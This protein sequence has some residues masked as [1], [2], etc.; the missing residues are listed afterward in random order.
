MIW[1]S[2]GLVFLTF[3]N[4]S[5]YKIWNI[6]AAN[7]F[8]VV[9]FGFSWNLAIGISNSVSI[10]FYSYI[11]LRTAHILSL[12]WCIHMQL[13][14][15]C[16]CFLHFCNLQFWKL[17]SLAN[18]KKFNKAKTYLFVYFGVLHRYWLIWLP[19]G[20]DIFEIRQSC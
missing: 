11:Y 8:L 6:H 16:H 12:G 18:Q 14:N 5:S 3:G 13:K 19:F 10:L 17:T 15:L 9:I 1:A 20:T 7:F 4:L 2:E